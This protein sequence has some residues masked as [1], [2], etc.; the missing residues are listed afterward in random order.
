[1]TFFALHSEIPFEQQA[2]VLNKLPNGLRKVIISTSI[3]ESS[4]TVPDVKYVIDFGLTK[5][6]HCDQTTNFSSLKLEWASKS[7]MNQRKGRAGR[8]SNG[9]CYRLITKEFYSKKIQDFP[10]PAILRQPLD[11]LILNIK[12]FTLNKSPKQI[13][14]LALTPPPEDNIDRTILYLKEVG[15]L[16]L[17]KNGEFCTDDGDLT[18]A[19]RIMNDLPVDL[20]LAKLILFGHVFGRTREAVIIA[21]ALSLRSL[22]S[23]YFNSTFEAYS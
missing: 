9:F 2:Q 16:T 23:K 1:L 10:A 5:I 13:L 12:R 14:A 19:G 20:K 4:I 18:Y 17:F 8:V 15:A 22:F 6:F 11:K 3:A 21:A 7:N